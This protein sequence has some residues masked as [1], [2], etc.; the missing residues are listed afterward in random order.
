LFIISCA[1]RAMKRAHSPASTPPKRKA[2]T[3][4]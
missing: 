1:V 3:D 4:G 2:C